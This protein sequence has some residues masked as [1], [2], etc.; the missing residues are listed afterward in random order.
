MVKNESVW[1]CLYNK[2][3]KFLIMRV[4]MQENHKHLLQ[5]SFLKNG[6]RTFP[7]VQWAIFC[8][9]PAC[10]KWKNCPLR[11]KNTSQKHFSYQLRELIDRYEAH[12]ELKLEISDAIRFVHRAWGDVT[13][14]T[15]KNCWRHV[16]LVSIEPQ[17][18]EVIEIEI[19]PEI[20]TDEFSFIVEDPMS[21]HQF[22][23][24]D[25]EV[26]TEPVIDVSNIAQIIEI[27]ATETEA[28]Q[29]EEEPI[30]TVSAK[31]A[32]SSIKTLIEFM[33]STPEFSVTEV[34]SLFKLQDKIRINQSKKLKQAKITQFF[35]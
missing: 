21:I 13:Q 19:S 4:Q 22:M 24:I 29:D 7:D 34:D 26:Q 30:A 35:N 33:E 11:R 9:T 6:Q 31:D 2:R 23:N 1:F 16:G 18:E 5:I 10:E 28:E 27:T 17:A 25:N 14:A 32:L 12:R 3:K 8:T 20:E 15:I